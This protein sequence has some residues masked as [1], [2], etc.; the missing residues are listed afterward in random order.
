MTMIILIG[1]RQRKRMKDMYVLLLSVLIS[2]L[3]TGCSTATSAIESPTQA[4]QPQDILIFEAD[5]TDGKIDKDTIEKAFED[6]GLTIDADN[7]MNRPFQ[8]RFGST[9]YK[10]YR[11]MT[12]H[13]ADIVAKLATEYPNIGLLT[14]L[15]MSIWSDDAK[16]SIKIS[17][18]SLRGM[19]RVTQIPMD[20]KALIAYAALMTKALEN[21][22]P[23]GESQLLPHHK[24][25]DMN[26][27]LATIFTTEFELDEEMTLEDAKDD[28]QS[29]FEG[30]MEPVG[31]LFP[32][33]VSVNDELEERDIESFDFF[34]TYSICKLDVIY[35][36]SKSHPEVGAYAPC[37]FFMY[38]K[39]DQAEVHMGFPSVQ[40]W[41]TSADITDKTSLEPLIEAQRMIEE[42]VKEV[43]E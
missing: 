38:K 35:P 33:F 4:S 12:V 31:F 40:N 13:S 19:S 14:P 20:N 22:L 30:E 5:N 26:A 6:A 2:W 28:F 41:V 34:D 23:G 43:T 21:A 25:A 37:T 16:K 15:S 27:S 32:G 7:D 18:L 36:V 3:M 11:L 42:V 9:H 24:V 10:T 8:A 29:E 39:K 17:S 1:I